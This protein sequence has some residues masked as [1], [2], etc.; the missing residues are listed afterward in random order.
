MNQISGGPRG[1]LVTDDTPFYRHRPTPIVT[2]ETT[3]QLANSL[4]LGNDPLNHSSALDLQLLL[5][6][7]IT[8]NGDTSATDDQSTLYI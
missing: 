5:L 7:V 2:A 1:Q 4:T 8:Q 3:S 6:R